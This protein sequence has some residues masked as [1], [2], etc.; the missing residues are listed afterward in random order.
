MIGC[1]TTLGHGFIPPATSAVHQTDAAMDAR[2][3]YAGEALPLNDSTPA[4]SPRALWRLGDALAGVEGPPNLGVALKAGRPGGKVK[5]I[6]LCSFDPHSL[7]CL[8]RGG[9]NRARAL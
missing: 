1:W 7:D 2:P 3:G 6:H 5:Y 4:F 9:L 8:R